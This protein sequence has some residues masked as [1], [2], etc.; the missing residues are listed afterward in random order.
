MHHWEQAFTYWLKHPWG[1][2]LKSGILIVISGI[3]L[4][5][6]LKD[7]RPQ[8]VLRARKGEWLTVKPAVMQPER[9][10]GIILRGLI[11]IY[12]TSSRANVVRDY[13]II[14]K[15]ADGAW[16]EMTC[17]HMIDDPGYDISEVANRTPLTIPPYSAVEAPVLGILTDERVRDIEVLIQVEDLFGKRFS[18][19]VSVTK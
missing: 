17:E 16:R 14:A 8:L 15:A 6:V 11:E 3:A 1:D 2:I 9:T 5:L 4:G 13:R 19:K 7:R 10:P 12:N 18:V